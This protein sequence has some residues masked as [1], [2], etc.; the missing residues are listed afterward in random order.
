MSQVKTNRVT[1]PMVDLHHV[2][3]SRSISSVIAME[4]ALAMV[5]N[6]K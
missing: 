5:G 4:V 1:R 2:Q 3:Q 6:V